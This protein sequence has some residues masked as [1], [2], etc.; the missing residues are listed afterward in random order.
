MSLILHI[1]TAVDTASI[2]LSNGTQLIAAD[3]NNQSRESAGWLQPAIGRLLASQDIGFRELQAVSVSEGPGSY[4]GLRVGM[5]SA[6]GLCYALGIPLIAVGTLEMMAAAAIAAVPGDAIFC[7]LID[8]RRMEV[9]TAMFDRDLAV[10]LPHCNL[11]LDAS[12][13]SD[14]LS[15]HRVVFSGNGSSKLKSLLDSP[16]AV[17]AEDVA[18]GATHMVPLAWK[19]FTMRNFADLAYAEPFYGKAAHT[20]QPRAQ[21]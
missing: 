7:P 2:C 5:A 16:S 12:S 1:D 10:R 4:T 13:F 3:S 20:T 9:F 18:A 17:F 6:K 21:R 15:E 14:W 8:A 19:K 11:I